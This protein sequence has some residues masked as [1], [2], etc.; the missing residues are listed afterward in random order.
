MKAKTLRVSLAFAS[1]SDQELNAFA[2]VIAVCMKN[3]AA[4]PTPPISWEAL[5]ALQVAFQN[6]YITAKT[7]GP[8]E[9]ALKNEAR[10]TLIEALRRLAAYVQMNCGNVLST[11]LSSGFDPVM[12]NRT[13]SPLLQPTVLGLENFATT[14]ILLRME[15]VA[16]AKAY[17]VQ[18]K[19]PT[20][21]WTDGGIYSQARRIVLFGLTPGSIYSVRVRAIGGSTGY[22]DWTPSISLMST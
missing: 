14:Q 10:D 8:K 5:S 4:F 22:S 19:A 9:T 15:P 16:N 18:I 21:D 3:N 13:Q 7:G 12:T 1:Y 6:A 17:Q 20:G 2:I 11:L